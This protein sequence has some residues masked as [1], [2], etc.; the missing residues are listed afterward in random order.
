M[1]LEEVLK[2]TNAKVGDDQEWFDAMRKWDRVSPAPK[3][4]DFGKSATDTYDSLKGFSIGGSIGWIPTFENDK[5]VSIIKTIDPNS[6]ETWFDKLVN[7]S[8]KPKSISEPIVSNKMGH[9]DTNFKAYWTNKDAE[10]SLFKYLSTFNEG[11]ISF[12]WSKHLD[13]QINKRQQDLEKAKKD[14]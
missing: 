12:R 2:I 9:K 11:A 14:F 4:H 6:V 5:L 10:I 13:Q 3:K 8:G 7:Q 1:S